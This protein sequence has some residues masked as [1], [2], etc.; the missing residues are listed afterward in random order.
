MLGAHKKYALV[1]KPRRTNQ[2]DEQTH[3][4]G[5]GTHMRITPEQDNNLSYLYI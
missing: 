2:D 3:I 1:S 4:Y 5:T